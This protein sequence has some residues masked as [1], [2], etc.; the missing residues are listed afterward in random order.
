[1]TFIRDYFKHTPGAV[2]MAPGNNPWRDCLAAELWLSDRGAIATQPKPLGICRFTETRPFLD[3]KL[4]DAC[5]NGIKTLPL[6]VVASSGDKADE[7]A[8]FAEGYKTEARFAYDAQFLYIAVTCAHP[9]GQTA[10]AAAKRHRDADLTGHDRVDIL[11]DMDRDYQTYY[12]FQ[13]DDRGCLAEDCWGD[14]SWNPKYFVAFNPTAAGWTAE[15]AIPLVEL[16]GDKPS[17]GRTWAANVTRVTPAK[18]I[19]AWSTPTDGEPRPEGMGLL[20]FR[21]ER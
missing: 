14:K 12:R 8:A 2:A 6:K 21:T 19:Q 7:A 18:G 11:L 1:E 17:T 15:L 20:Q 5:W 13:I 16:T 10:P 3:G 9:T 4:D